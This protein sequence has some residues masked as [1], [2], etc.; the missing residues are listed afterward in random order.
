MKKI[1]ILFS[2]LP[3][4]WAKLISTEVVSANQIHAEASKQIN[5]IETFTNY[6][7]QFPQVDF[8]SSMRLCKSKIEK[9]KLNREVFSR[10]EFF[11]EIYEKNHLSKVNFAAI[12]KIP[13]IIHQIWLGSKFPELYKNIT[14]KWLDLHPSWKYILW[15]DINV[16]SLF[17]LHNQAY[18]D[19]AKNFAEKS[20]ILRYEI[21]YRF[22][23]LYVDIDYE[24][25]KPFDIF[26][27]SYD[28]FAGIEPI[29]MISFMVGVAIIGSAPK[30]PY[31]KQSI[32]T[33]KDF[34][35]LKIL[36][37]RTGPNHL[38]RAITKI[39]YLENVILF[40]STYLYPLNCP[41]KNA[42]FN[43]INYLNQ[44]SFGIHY[45]FGTWVKKI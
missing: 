43:V 13:K 38:T 8:Y 2:L 34:R 17:P 24:C 20:D 31:L 32:D 7:K 11:R 40:P 3:S 16:K 22:G 36:G 28:F 29:T 33:I 18:F 35:H 21:L 12:S 1:I 23:G 5:L 27:H 39:G 26:M 15:D 45:Y 42:K 9:V 10:A 4:F 44:E 6:M 25:L 19:A 30:H 37:E 14:Q 41:I